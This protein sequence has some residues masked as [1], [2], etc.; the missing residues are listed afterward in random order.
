M[1]YDKKDLT[2]SPKVKGN[3]KEL[4]EG[5]E[6][7]LIRG[8]WKLRDAEGTLLIFATEELAWEHINGKED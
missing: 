3:K 4:P 5:W 8:V 2:K 6:L 1:E 7:N